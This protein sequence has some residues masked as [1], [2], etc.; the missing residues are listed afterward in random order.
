MNQ[1]HAWTQETLLGLARSFMECRALL[2]AAELDL[3]TLLAKS[4]MSADDIAH[5]LDATPRALTIL[6]DCLTA[7]GL[8]IKRGGTYQAEPSAAR[9]L[10][11]DTPQSVLPMVRHCVGL[12]ERWS[13]L[14]NVVAPTQ[15]KNSPDSW[16]EAFI[17]AMHSIAS[18]TAPRIVTLTRPGEARRL[19]DVGGASGTYT[20]AFLCQAPTMQATLFDRPAVIDM[21][22]DRIRAAGMLDRV[23]LV[24]GDFY[25]DPLPAGHDLAFV[26]AIIH[27][28]SPGQNVELFRKVHDALVPSGRIVIRDHVLSPDRTQPTRGALFAV[29]MLV[30]TSGG[31]SYTFE[32]IADALGQAGFVNVGLLHPDTQMDGL[33]EAFK[34][35]ASL[36]NL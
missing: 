36:P 8:L 30:A 27:Q 18:E 7:M 25:T 9:V 12:W 24:K 31:N 17:G 26:S 19:L 5:C 33:V 29:N 21:A 32:E 6:L 1:P 35:A 13:G 2:T 4:P 23:N 22:R 11:A 20:L 34:P 28:N 3:F 10:A 15:S 14:T 16:M